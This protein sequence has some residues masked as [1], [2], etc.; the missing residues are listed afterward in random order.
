MIHGKSTFC[1]AFLVSCCYFLCVSYI[2]IANA[3]R[4]CGTVLK[5]PERHLKC[6]IKV[7][8]NINLTISCP[9]EE[10]VALCN[11]Y[12]VAIYSRMSRMLGKAKKIILFQQTIAWEKVTIQFGNS[13]LFS[14]SRFRWRLEDHNE[15]TAPFLV[16]F[17]M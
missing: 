14:A 4:S 17:S 1:A 13:Y 9:C 5:R 2:I 12:L 16:A 7:H 8:G 3:V 10:R 6:I 15:R 11:T